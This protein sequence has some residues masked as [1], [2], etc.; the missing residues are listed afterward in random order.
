M[1]RPVRELRDEGEYPVLLSHDLDMVTQFT[2]HVI[3][4]DHGRRVHDGPIDE[5]IRIVR[6][7]AATRT[8]DPLHAVAPRVASRAGQREP[9][10]LKRAV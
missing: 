1:A 2:G 9:G 8:R 6:I 4:L 3:V 7:A 5:A 10:R